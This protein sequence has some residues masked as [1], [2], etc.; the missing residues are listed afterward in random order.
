MVLMIRWISMHFMRDADLHNI[1]KT[2]PPIYYT[3]ES[4]DLTTG[5]L[6]AEPHVNAIQADFC[7][8]KMLL[9]IAVRDSYLFTVNFKSMTKP[10]RYAEAR[11]IDNYI[12]YVEKEGFT[13]RLR[14]DNLPKLHTNDSPDRLISAAQSLIG[15]GAARRLRSGVMRQFLRDPDAPSDLRYGALPHARKIIEAI[16]V[17]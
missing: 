7:H 2:K 15:V 14:F 3:D 8:G 6:V 13:A 16:P 12:S 5:Q 1:I 9:H 4:Y 11:R 17:L 10:Q